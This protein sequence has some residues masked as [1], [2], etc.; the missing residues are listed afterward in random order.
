MKRK[1]GLWIGAGLCCLAAVGGHLSNRKS[2][3]VPTL[4]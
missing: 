2:G 1:M 3:F 4:K